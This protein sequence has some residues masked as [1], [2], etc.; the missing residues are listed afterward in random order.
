MRKVFLAIA[1][2]VGCGNGGG[3]N[4]GVYL[5]EVMYHPVLEGTKDEEHEFVEIHNGGKAAVDISGW[6]LS[7]GVNYTFPVGTTVAPDGYLVIAKNKQKLV[8]VAAY[9]LDAAT[10]N[11]DFT[12]DL[13]NGGELVRLE[14][15]A[16]K[17][18]DEFTYDDRFP[19]PIG[20]DSLGASDGWLPAS[21]LPLEKH[22]YMGRSLERVS[23]QIAA[24]EVANWVASPI[25]GPTPGRKNNLDGAPP[26]IVTEI[27]ARVAGRADD[28]VKAEESVV[29]RVRFS[30]IGKVAAPAVEWFVDEVEVENEAR[31][32]TALVNGKD[33]VWTAT[34][35]PQSVNSIVR[36]RVVE[37]TPIS[38]RE[39]DPYEF[40]AFFVDP[41]PVGR[42]A[43]YHLFISQKNWMQ[44][45]NNVVDGRVPGNQNWSDP[46]RCKP[47]ETWDVRVPATMVSDGRVYDV[48]ARYQGSRV[49]RMS[50]ANIDL[51]KWPAT[52]PIP[53]QPSPFRA[54]SW[55]I[56]FPRYQRFNDG[57]DF[58]DRRTFNLNKLTQSCQGFQ[59]RVNNRLF[60]QAGVGAA[61]AKWVRFHVNGALYH[62]MLQMEHLDEEFLRR[63]YGKN[64]Q[65]GD[66]FKSVG[67]RWEEGPYGS[68]AEVLIPPYCGYTAEERYN[69]TYKRMTLKDWKGNSGE[70]MKLVID[71]NAARAAG[72]PAMRKFFADNFDMELLLNYFGVL[73]W[74]APW[75]DFFQNHFLYKRSDGKWVIFPTDQDNS[76]G[77]G[78]PSASDASFFI[79]VQNA[80][81]NRSD[82]WNTLKDSFLRAYRNEF[83][84]RVRELAKTVLSPDNVWAATDEL[85][86]DY[87]Y[88]DAVQ[89]P[90]GVACGVPATSI[91]R[92]KNFAVARHQR[93]LAGFWD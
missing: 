80:R 1:V 92:M 42:T 40:R 88:E 52:V 73:Q 4:E 2:C 26:A 27:V 62:H 83:I 20:A 6:R 87:A 47:S 55:H 54:L 49:N 39:S 81:S 22:R 41:G 66:L 33:G 70:A 44:M 56:N 34:I 18:V 16:G 32:R 31:T 21:A 11:G 74:L 17:I 58:V 45:W 51:R 8:A 65:V 76:M 75:D 15:H 3:S 63:F 86:A 57:K 64:H 43:A 53:P 59:T 67:Y 9:G 5:S 35:P 82:Y 30:T 48:T 25:D 7:K 79:G 78:A 29:L 46:T 72:L 12:G 60:E 23:Y 19:W 10:V 90:A 37:T 61:R 38:P 50:G 85:T 24:S 93:V 28:I 71:L 77:G 14:D 36:Y 13:D 69:W 84:D 89:S 91:T 68:G